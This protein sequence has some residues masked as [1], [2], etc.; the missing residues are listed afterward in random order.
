[1]GDDGTKKDVLPIGFILKKE[2]KLKQIESYLHDVGF[3][4][5]E[6]HLRKRK[7]CDALLLIVFK[8]ESVD[9]DYIE[10]DIKELSRLAKKVQWQLQWVGNL[11]GTV[12]PY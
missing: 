8:M 3:H 10:F 7:G 12:S 1:M 11:C 9:R 2:T 6:K 4:T 5:M